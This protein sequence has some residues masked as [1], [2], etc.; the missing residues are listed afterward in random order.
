MFE[1]T[2]KE[3]FVKF[4]NSMDNFLIAELG[5]NKTLGKDTFL[6]NA[7]D[8]FENR[9]DRNRLMAAFLDL[10]ITR[11][12]LLI[13]QRDV[14]GMWNKVS[15]VYGFKDEDPKPRNILD[16]QIG[17]NLKMKILNRSWDGI[18]RKR[19]YWDK[20]FGVVIMWLDPE[21]YNSFVNS[22]SRK[23]AFMK[24]VSKWEAIPFH[25]IEVIVRHSQSL[26]NF[27][28]VVDN[29][30]DNNISPQE[31]LD[32]LFNFIN[33]LNDY[34]TP[35][36]HG[37]GRLRKFTLVNSALNKSQDLSMHIRSGNVIN[38]MHSGLQDSIVENPNPHPEDWR[39][40]I[41]YLKSRR[42][43]ERLSRKSL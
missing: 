16:D 11:K 40:S 17:F 6:S 38:S 22:K 41:R 36:A 18:L 4:E 43:H 29:L 3:D 9:E 2:S 28:E 35:E 26:P 31:F 14:S 23:K 20:F 24:I 30:Y 42:I 21:N 13:D 15:K 12:F 33:E 34:R 37:T 25:L 39:K 19:A 5:K 10:T 8:V 7:F 27:H 1:L 32:W